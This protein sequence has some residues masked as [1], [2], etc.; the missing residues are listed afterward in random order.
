MSLPTTA[1]KKNE[2]DLLKTTVL[3]TGAQSC[4][5]RKVPSKSVSDRRAQETVITLLGLDL[6][7]FEFE[8]SVKKMNHHR[9][10]VKTV[11]EKCHGIKA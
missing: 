7:E 10:M 6:R 2:G 4:L 11:H 9:S 8:K 1:T 3:T 5:V